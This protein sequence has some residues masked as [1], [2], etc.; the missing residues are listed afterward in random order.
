MQFVTV[1][2]ERQPTGLPGGD[3]ASEQERAEQLLGGQSSMTQGQVP[4][5]TGL[6]RNEPKNECYAGP[7]IKI[8]EQGGE[9]TEHNCRVF[10]LKNR[11][12]RNNVKCQ[13]LKL[14]G[15]EFKVTVTQLLQSLIFFN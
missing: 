12:E 3:S 11:S 8:K 14:L 4:K 7:W 13:Y 5:S 9:G 1:K 6:G 15:G 2:D 10:S